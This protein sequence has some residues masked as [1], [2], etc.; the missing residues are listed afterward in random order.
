MHQGMA[1]APWVRLQYAGI[2]FEQVGFESKQWTSGFNRA[3]AEAGRETAAT[4]HDEI[5]LTTPGIQAADDAE[6]VESHCLR[7]TTCAG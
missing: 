5:F 3:I 7:I 6:I 1:Y 4:S 2:G